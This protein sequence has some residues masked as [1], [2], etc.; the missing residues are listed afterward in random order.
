[1]TQFTGLIQRDVHGV[2][3]IQPVNIRAWQH[4]RA[5]VTRIQ[6]KDVTYHLVLVRLNNAGA[7]A[8]SQTGLDLLGGHGLRTVVID[9]QHAQGVMGGRG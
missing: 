2:T 3:G 9:A 6:G 8:L 4:D 7:Q 5:E 1:M